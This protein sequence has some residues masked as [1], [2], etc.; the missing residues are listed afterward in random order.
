MAI[1]RAAI[2]HGKLQK[3]GDAEGLNITTGGKMDELIKK[4]SV[5]PAVFF[6]DTNS[7][8]LLED[9]KTKAKDFTP[10]LST[11]KGRK[12]IAS[13]AAQVA[14]AKVWLDDLGKNLVAD[15]KAEI[16]KVDSARK[17]IRDSL[18]YLKAEI[19]DPLTVYETQMKEIQAKALA[20]AEYLKDWD[21]AVGMDDLF[22]RE[23]KVKEQEAEIQKERDE[24]AKKERE[25]F[26]QKQAADQAKKEVEEKAEKEKQE[27]RDKETNARIA[28]DRAE[29]EK[30]E[31]I[32]NA[33]KEKKE[34]VE[35]EKRR[36]AEEKRLAD[37]V[38]VQNQ[39]E[40]DRKAADKEH[41][42]TI[43]TQAISGLILHGIDSATAS[44]VVAVISK[45]MVRHLTI[46]Y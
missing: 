2:V 10:D 20:L 46:N 4:E 26:L 43:E 40:A 15:K 30:E 25:V 6:M 42:R 12:E 39:K 36:A 14:S 9:M 8:P 29:R 11:D 41:R 19:R 13:R 32:A 24:Q 17:M 18:V 21:E 28:A 23:R 1:D 31:A 33:E 22:E 5:T 44:K 3:S 38:E 45:K 37:E 35:A 34:A 27:L 7:L 16:G